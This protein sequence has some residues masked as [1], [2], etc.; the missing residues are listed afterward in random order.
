MQFPAPKN[1]P[2][3]RIARPS[4]GGGHYRVNEISSRDA[5]NAFLAR[6]RPH[7]FLQS[8]EWGEFNRRQGNRVYR[9][10]VWSGPEEG[11]LCTVAQ[12]VVIAARRATFLFCPHGPVFSDPAARASLPALVSHLRTLGKQQGVSF[13]RFSSMLSDT[14]ESRVLLRQL[15]FRNAPIH[16]HPEL[17]WLLDISRNEEQLLQGMRKTTRYLIRRSLQGNLEIL[18]GNSAA[19][20]EEFLKLYQSTA[21]RQHFIAFPERY[22][23]DELEAF[24]HDAEIL[25]A[26]C[27]GSV[28]AGA[29][30]VYTADSAF[31]HHGATLPAAGKIPAAY[32]LQ[33]EAIRTAQQRGC[34]WYNFWGIAPAGNVRHPWHGL[35]Q[36][37]QGFGGFPEAYLHAQD[38]AISWRYWLNYLIERA[39]RARRGL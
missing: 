1:V 39:R 36:F 16:M 21:Q 38:L 30:I 5:W 29:F 31:Y 37:K 9:F 26:R 6:V 27:D 4:P 3:S 18:R 32:R 28:I 19:E 2:L 15:H 14:Q 34:R 12:V 8:W 17:A 25:L 10:G 33:W 24:G 13:L 35:S 20:L 22:L 7:T 11:S 23:R